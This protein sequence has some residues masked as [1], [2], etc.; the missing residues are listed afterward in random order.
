MDWKL[1]LVA[2]P[3]SDVDRA[4]AFYTEKAGFNADHDHRVSDEVRFVQLTPPG[5]ACSI[6]IGSGISQSEPGSVQGMQLVVSD[7]N[8]ARTELAERGVDVS[9]VQEF[10]WGSF[11]FFS[12]PDGNGWAVQQIPAR[13]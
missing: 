13:D 12:D 9:E 1:E 10:D 4:K 11:V 7:I 5:S 3:V 2:V 6:A 8:A